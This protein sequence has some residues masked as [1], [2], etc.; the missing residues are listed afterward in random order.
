MELAERYSAVRAFTEKLCQP[1]EIEDYV[2]QSMPD[3]SPTRWHLAHTTW[4]FETFVLTAADA[5]NQTFHPAFV[6]L[7]NSYYNA[8][9]PQFPRLQ[10]GLLTRPTV[11]E[12]YAYRKHVDEQ[13]QRLLDDDERRETGNRTHVIELGLQHEQ[14]H[15]ELMLT[16]LKHVFAQNPL[17]PVYR[18]REI[19]PSLPVARLRWASFAEGLRQIGFDGD[20]FCYDNE[21]PRHRE[22]LEGFEL[23]CRLVTNGEYLEF[24]EAGGYR[25]PAHWLSEGWAAVQQHG[26]E[27]PLYWQRRDGAWWNF[28]LSGLRPMDPAEPVC[29][30]SFYEADAYARWAGCRLP[31]EAE[32]ETA[33]ASLPLDGRFVEDEAYHPQPLAQAANGMNPQQMFGDVWEWTASP[34]VPYPGFRAA[35]GAIGE[36][37]GKFMCN[38]L[39]L[40][41]GSCATSRSHIRATYRNFFHPPDR[42]QFTGIRLAR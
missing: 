21:R 41:G 10:R 40:R 31:S 15:Q 30:I 38:Q 36:Y 1:L 20:G 11:K 42:W 39:V 17:Y 14:Q 26:W 27:A 22:F 28:T 23:A 8:V 24:M 19:P 9:G 4:F 13:M 3:V 32:W 16:D 5:A 35:A 6:E 33:A 25:E 37:N 7:F 18:A 29:H 34:Y 12:V 2:V